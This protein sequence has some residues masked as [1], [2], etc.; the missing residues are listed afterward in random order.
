[1]GYWYL[2]IAIVAEVI[3]TLSLK[4]SNGFSQLFY[5]SVCVVGYIAA[6]Y[7]LSLV[8][9][10]VPV[11]IAYAIWAGMGI[12]LVAAISAIIYKQVPDLPAII[13]MGL[14]LAGVAIMNLY[15]KTGAH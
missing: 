7:F 5:S 8:L 6:F 14:I 15:S 1:M 13:G 3:A 12:I 9:K 4:A 2:A 11:G 10:S